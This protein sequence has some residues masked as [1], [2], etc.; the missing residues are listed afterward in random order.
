MIAI[1]GIKLLFKK[2]NHHQIL[3][4]L[5]HP[6]GRVVLFRA[7]TFASHPYPIFEEKNCFNLCPIQGVVY[8][9]TDLHT[10]TETYPRGTIS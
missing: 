8:L 7:N 10:L 6:V 3:A 4:H 2:F 5:H 9:F 1:N